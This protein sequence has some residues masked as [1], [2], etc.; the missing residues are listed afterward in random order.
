[1]TRTLAVLALILAAVAPARAGRDEDPADQNVCRTVHPLNDR[2]EA[3][4]RY[5]N[6]TAEVYYTRRLVNDG[7]LDYRELEAAEAAATAAG[8]R[9]GRF[10]ARMLERIQA[11]KSFASAM[12][13]SSYGPTTLIRRDNLAALGLIEGQDYGLT[14]GLCFGRVP[15]ANEPL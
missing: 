6:A 11:E 8:E 10:D 2:M 3:L 14:D 9:L 12:K 13:Y 7:E 5:G 4:L 1:M 15:R